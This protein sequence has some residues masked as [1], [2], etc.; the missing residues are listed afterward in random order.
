MQLLRP[1]VSMLGHFPFSTSRFRENSHSIY[2]K[3]SQSSAVGCLQ[4]TIL[5]PYFLSSLQSIC[6]L[7]VALFIHL[8]A[9]LLFSLGPSSGMSECRVSGRQ[10]LRKVAAN[11]CLGQGFANRGSSHEMQRFALNPKTEFSGLFS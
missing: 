4:P 3:S 11:Q 7:Y 6:S 9:L 2:L 8:F 10:S 5:S 1:V